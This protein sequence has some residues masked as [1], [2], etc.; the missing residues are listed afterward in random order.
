MNEALPVAIVLS[1][2]INGL[3]AVRTLAERGVPVI[4]VGE[5][6]RDIGLRSRYPL[7]RH[8]LEHNR[9]A[10]GV[11]ELRTL[12]GG[13]GLDRAVLVPT[14]DWFVSA[15][16][17]DRMRLPEG[18]CIAAPDAPLVEMLVDKAVETARVGS[19]LPIPPTVTPLPPTHEELLA[20]LRTP[21]IVKPRSF[22]HMCIGG[23]NVVLRSADDARAFYARFPDVRDRVVAQEVIEGPDSNLWVCHAAFDDHS[24]MASAFTFRR[25]RLSP[26]HYGVT[27]YAVSERNEEVVALVDRLGRA[28]GYRG[29]AMVEFKW[30][31]RD[32]TYR[33]IELNPRLGL[34]NYF[35]G[36]CGPGTAYVAYR[37]AA[38][39]S[40]G[41]VGVQRDGAVFV[42]LYED[43]YSRRHDGETLGAIAADYLRDFGQQ[44]V[45]AYWSLRDPLPALTMAYRQAG[46]LLGAFGR[47]LQGARR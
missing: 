47:R 26:P 27:S 21:I 4:V 30:D 12:L 31:P 2:G 5:T 14:S 18:F 28:L 38:G 32:S 24:R 46:E 13:L 40:V 29:P 20:Q 3:G 36:R 33:Y 10:P 37:L 45:F 43:L 19:V 44:H 1:A 42:S 22:A 39:L 9:S 11:G 34:A 41:D 6:L 7:A 16:R 17:S 23:K 25:L 8:C 35:D 15:L